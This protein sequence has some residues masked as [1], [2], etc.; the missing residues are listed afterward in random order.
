MGLKDYF[1]GRI[2][3]RL[4]RG[5]ER[6]R[7]GNWWYWVWLNEACKAFYAD[8]NIV[9]FCDENAFELATTVSEIFFPIDAIADR[10]AGLKY[11][12][13]DKDGNT[14]EP[15]ANIRRLLDNPN[16]FCTSFSD[17]VYNSVFNELSDGNDYIFTKTPRSLKGIS[18]DT[19]SSVWVL[20]PDRVGVKIKNIRP[21]YFDIT[22]PSD[23][24]EYYE[25]NLYEKERIDP[26]YIIHSRSLAMGD[27]RCGLKSPSPLRAAERNINN[28]LAVYSARYKVYAHNG[29]AG[30]LTRDVNGNNSLEQAVDPTTRDEIIEDIL[31]RNGL[32]GDKKLWTVSAIPLRF[33]KTLATISELQ[34]FE[35]T[36][37]DALQIAGVM[38]VDKDLIPMKEGTTYSNKEQ[39]E[40]NIYQNQVNIIANNK[41]ES[42]TRAF[43]LNQIGL[44]FKP[45]LADVPVMQK[46]KETELQGDSLLIDNIIKMKD[47][48]LIGDKDAQGIIEKII[49]NYRNG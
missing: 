10:V 23:V 44:R 29:N 3:N 22:S 14:V 2:D 37:A 11:N 42:F 31:N 34:P 13:E 46:D 12:V 41:A 30:I 33:I 32:V 39:A 5:A 27:Y 9:R 28:I 18:P 20:R 49:E 15:P 24:I 48:L 8:D 19:I 7:S 43:G 45:S 47:S 36:M 4:P 26:R 38:G 1:K 21:A 25:Y 35:E 40:K 17:L 16:P 6:D